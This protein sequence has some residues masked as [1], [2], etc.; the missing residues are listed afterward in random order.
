[1]QRAPGRGFGDVELVVAAAEGV[2]PVT[3]AIAPRR[4]H[5]AAAARRQ[6]AALVAVQHV[7]AGCGV[8]AQ[9]AT[10][11]DDHD[12]LVTVVQDPLAPTDGYREVPRDAGPPSRP[13]RTGRIRSALRRLPG[14]GV[15]DVHRTTVVRRPTRPS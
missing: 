7:D 1:V 14:H 3:D 6:L 2:L 10:D 8:P 13:R 4:E 15:L 9:P 11:L 5:L 12:L